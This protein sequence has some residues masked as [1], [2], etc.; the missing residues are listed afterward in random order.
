M[1]LQDFIHRLL[2]RQDEFFDLLERQAGVARK[3]AEALASF[4]DRVGLD[5][6]RSFVAMLRQSIELGTDV[7]DALRVFSD[8]MRDKRLLRAE[9]RA[10][11]LPVKMVG[12]LGLCIFPVILGLV[13]LPVVI[14]I[15]TVLFAM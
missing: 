13:L 9:E 10:N 8:E 5:E 3:A 14:R 12:P 7:G 6:A 15:Y 2:P 11:Q 1:G 4:A